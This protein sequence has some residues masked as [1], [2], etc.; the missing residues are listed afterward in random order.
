MKIFDD[1]FIKLKKVMNEVKDS[2]QVLIKLAVIILPIIILIFIVNIII[3]GVRNNNCYKLRSEIGEY[4][5]D[6]LLE[7]DVLP[8]ING[9]NIVINLED[10]KKVTFKDEVC[11][12]SVKI[13]KVNDQYIKTFYLENCSYCTTQEFN[14]ESSKYNADLNADVI[15]YLNYYNITYGNSRWSDY[16]PFEEIDTEETNGVLLPVDKDLLPD[17]SEEAIIT[18][19][20]KE[21]KNFYS[22]RDKRWLWYRNYNNSYSDFSSEKPD[23]YEKKD[24]KTEINSDYTEWSIDYPEVKDYRVISSATGYRWYRKI[25][26][27]VVWWNNGEYYPESPGDDY[28][29]DNDSKITMY[30][31]YDKMW[32]WYNGQERN[33]A[34]SQS[35]TP[36]SSYYK[37]KDEGI[38]SY[39]SWSSYSTS[40]SLTSDNSSYREEI[41]NVHSR[42]L[43]KYKIKSFLVLDESL[44]R[45]EFEKT[46]GRT[47]E[48]MLDDANVEV[49][50]TFKYKY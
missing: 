26:G 13:T 22:Y 29:K 5:D 19:I 1:L 43:I 49:E 50:I 20:I 47:L 35:S 45:S 40:S 41:V 34:Y 14:K 33:Y 24:E 37:Y 30:R 3:N 25:D 36:P 17:I 12:G 9:D 11:T 4:V 27:E 21:D 10:I 15:V 31:Y 18:E 2:K 28:L 39:T 23:G 32:R 46:V 6:Y 42:Y 8:T 44:E 38:S 48:E 16:I 7:N